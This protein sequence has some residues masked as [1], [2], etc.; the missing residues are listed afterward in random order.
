[1][2]NVA[3]G[4]RQP[5]IRDHRMELLK[6]GFGCSLTSNRALSAPRMSPLQLATISSIA[7]SFGLEFIENPPILP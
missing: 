1:V 7:A 5:A 2:Q 6:F 4:S 3:A